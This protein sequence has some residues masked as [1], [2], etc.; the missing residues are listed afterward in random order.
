MIYL[1]ISSSGSYQLNSFNPCMVSN[2]TKNTAD[3][4]TEDL[5]PITSVLAKTS[6]EERVTDLN[7]THQGRQTYTYLPPVATQADLLTTY[8]ELFI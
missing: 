6:I 4:L 1:I 7:N 3:L 2:F 5:H 8:P